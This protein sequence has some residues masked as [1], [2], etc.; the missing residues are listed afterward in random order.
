MLKVAHLSAKENKPGLQ[1]WLG[2]V[3]VSGLGFPLGQSCFAL[4]LLSKWTTCTKTDAH[5]QKSQLVY[6]RG[7]FTSG[8]IHNLLAQPLPLMS[9]SSLPHTTT[10]DISCVEH[11]STNTRLRILVKAQT[12]TRSTWPL[13]PTRLGIPLRDLNVNTVKSRASAHPPT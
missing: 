1:S 11:C 6:V 5:F 2:L 13:S 9:N 4:P 8:S 3:L 12:S 7:S 10:V